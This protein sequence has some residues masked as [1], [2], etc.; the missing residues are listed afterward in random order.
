MNSLSDKYALTESDTLF[1]AGISSI[2]SAQGNDT[3]A[4]VSFLRPKLID[5]AP[6]RVGNFSAI[7]KEAGE[8]IEQCWQYVVTTP[9]GIMLFRKAKKRNE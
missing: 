8:L 4:Y 5:R 1:L 7:A 2:K 6:D 3:F 9:Q